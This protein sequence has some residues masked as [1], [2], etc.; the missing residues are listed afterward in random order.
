MPKITSPLTSQLA[1]K[2]CSTVLSHLTKNAIQNGLF[3]SVAEAYTVHTQANAAQKLKYYIYRKCQKRVRLGTEEQL[4][5][6]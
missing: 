1:L 6:D 2:R 5:A 3:T 4:G